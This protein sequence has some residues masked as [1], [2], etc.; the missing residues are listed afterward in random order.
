M[1]KTDDLPIPTVTI[2]RY[3]ACRGD[4]GEA[5]SCRILFDGVHVADASYDGNGG[6]YFY[7]WVRAG[8]QHAQA[9]ERW[10]RASSAVQEA[11][12]EHGFKDS[13]P[14]LDIAFE[15]VIAEHLLLRKVNRARCLYFRRE[16]GGPI[17]SLG[18]SNRYDQRFRDI[19]LKRHPQAVFLN[20]TVMVPGEVCK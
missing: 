8:D 2:D 13:D 7:R 6:P 19:V 15:A 4:E 17:F 14:L 3:R 10:A 18:R 11:R 16:P 5:F 20:A 1:P 12:R 9:F